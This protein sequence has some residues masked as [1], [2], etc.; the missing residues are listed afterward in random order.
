MHNENLSILILD[1]SMH[2]SFN[3]SRGP[4]NLISNFPLF[5]WRGGA[6]SIVKIFYFRP[7][8]F[9]LYK[10]LKSSCGAQAK[11]FLLDILIS[12]DE[13]YYYW[14]DA[15]LFRIF[16]TYAAQKKYCLKFLHKGKMRQLINTKDRV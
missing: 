10:A 13:L 6:G 3:W 12:L 14:R 5:I 4:F 15:S 7:P 2:P 1:C 16:Y 9:P 8:L 11:I